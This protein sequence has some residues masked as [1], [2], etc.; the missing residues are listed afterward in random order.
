[1]KRK[2]IIIV[3]RNIWRNQRGY[4]QFDFFIKYQRVE[5]TAQLEN[6]LCDLKE[7]TRSSRWYKEAKTITPKSYHKWMYER[8]SNRLQT[9]DENDYQRVENTLNEI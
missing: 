1:M 9:I 3:Q 8:K 7:L 2:Q 4:E 5:N 6:Q